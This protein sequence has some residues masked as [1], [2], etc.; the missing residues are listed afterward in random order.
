MPK[1]DLTDHEAEALQ[2]ALAWWRRHLQ[3]RP[4][5][6]LT[7]LEHGD[8]LEGAADKLDQ[9]TSGPAPDFPRP[10]HRPVSRVRDRRH[11]GR[12]RHHGYGD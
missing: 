3:R 4:S 1:L 8:A 2:L 11:N 12:R 6:T 9:A 10:T 5:G 7:W